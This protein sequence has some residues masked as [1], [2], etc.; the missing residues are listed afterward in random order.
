MKLSD[1]VE[2]IIPVEG[3]TVGAQ[4]K[5]VVSVKDA[6]NAAFNNVGGSKYLERRAE[7]NPKAFMGLLGKVIPAEIHAD[8]NVI[9]T[10]D[11]RGALAEARSRAITYENDNQLAINKTNDDNL[12]ELE[13]IDKTNDILL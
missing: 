13:V 5:T 11:I 4:V 6:L 7:D 10:V 12:L 8:I 3:S 2:A 9:H 1:K